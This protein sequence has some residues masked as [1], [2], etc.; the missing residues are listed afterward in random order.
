MPSSQSDLTLLENNILM[1]LSAL[2]FEDLPDQ[3]QKIFADI[4]IQLEKKS[5]KLSQHE[6]F[7][8]SRAPKKIWPKYLLFRKKFLSLATENNT[9]SFPLYLLIEPVSI[10]N[11]RC[12]MC[13]QSDKSFSGKKEFMGRMDFNLFKKIIDEAE[14]GGTQAITLASRGDPTMHKQLP[15]ML[16]YMKGKFLEIKLNTNGILLTEDLSISILENQVNDLVFS[17]DSYEKKNYEEIRK[18]AKFNKV[19]SNINQFIDIRENQYP[20][21]RTSVRVSG[22]KIDHKQDTKKYHEFWSKMVD[23]SMLIEMQARWN[24]YE[25]EII[26]SSLMLPCGDLWERMYIWWD[27][28]VNPCD[29]DY[30]S[31][32]AVGDVNQSSIRDIWNNENYT[33]LRT[34]HLNEQRKDFSVCSKCDAFLKKPNNLITHVQE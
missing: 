10:C 16:H 12:V 4:K 7:Y 8:L 24:T 9:S 30:K 3:E 20:A 22:V 1:E 34:A 29:V 28:K 13:F 26:D 14:A 15:D 23:Y 5:R 6:L 18:K 17:I 33:K 25:N 11:L 27:G 32:L 21:H 2:S 19:I 31:T